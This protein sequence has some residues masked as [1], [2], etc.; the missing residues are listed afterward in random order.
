MALAVIA[1]FAIVTLPSLSDSSGPYRVAE[2][3]RGIH[4]R[5]VEA[6][7]RATA[8]GRS[9]RLAFSAGTFYEMQV[10]GGG[11]WTLVGAPD[12][13]GAGVSFTVGGGTDGTVTFGSHGRAVAARSI[14]V[15]N[16]QHE[17]VIQIMAS[18]MAVWN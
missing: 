16:G 8:E 1:L 5:L 6:R 14:V 10:E 15:D 12:T 13:L 4:S 17:Q 11:S 7:A 3:A 9:Y 18:G 2:E